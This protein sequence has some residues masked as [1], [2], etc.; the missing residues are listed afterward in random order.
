MPYNIRFEQ[1]RTYMM[2]IGLSAHCYRNR[3]LDRES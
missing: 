3:M 2:P 1:L